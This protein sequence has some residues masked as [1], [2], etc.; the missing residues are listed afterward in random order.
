MRRQSSQFYTVIS[1]FTSDLT[2][3]HDFG[4]LNKECSNVIYFLLYKNVWDIGIYLKPNIKKKGKYLRNHPRQ[5]F[6]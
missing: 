4:I 3:L 1:L 6:P 2:D 5:T